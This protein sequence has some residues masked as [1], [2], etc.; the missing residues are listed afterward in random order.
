M[1]LT[2][3]SR[4]TPPPVGGALLQVRCFHDSI[5]NSWL[6]NQVSVCRSLV[7]KRKESAVRGGRVPVVTPVWRGE[8]TI[9]YS[10]HSKILRTY[11]NGED[12]SLRL[13]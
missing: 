9:C 4:E 2:G 8:R 7:T 3:V 10:S 1:S 13:H 12:N 5:A 6:H 11:E